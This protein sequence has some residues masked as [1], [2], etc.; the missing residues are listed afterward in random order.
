MLQSLVR[1][2]MG[3]TDA[4][5]CVNVL[6][7]HKLT[8]AHLLRGLGYMS[9]SGPSAERSENL[10]LTL[11]GAS[12][13]D[14]PRPSMPR[15]CAL[16]VIE[17]VK[18]KVLTDKMTI[19]SPS[20]PYTIPTPNPAEPAPFAP[21]DTP[22]CPSNTAMP[23]PV[24]VLVSLDA[25][26]QEPVWRTSCKKC[27][28]PSITGNYGFCGDHRE[29]STMT[30]NQR[31]QQSM[32]Y[33]SAA[34]DGQSI[35]SVANQWYSYPALA[36]A[37]QQAAVQAQHQAQL[38][39]QQ[40]QQL[41]AQQQA[42]AQANAQAQVQAQAQQQA[43]LKTQQQA[44]L[45]AQQQAQA[46]AE[47]LQVAAARVVQEVVQPQAPIQMM[48]V[49]VPTEVQTHAPAVQRYSLLQMQRQPAEVIVQHASATANAI[50][51]QGSAATDGEKTAAASTSSAAQNANALAPGVKAVMHGLVK[52][53]DL[54]GCQCEC[55]NYAADNG[56]WLIKVVGASQEQVF[57]QPKNLRVTVTGGAVAI[58]GAVTT[59]GATHNEQHSQ[60]VHSLAP[61]Q[62]PTPVPTPA[63]FIYLD[64]D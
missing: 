62:V 48:S 61:P 36:E 27:D 52:R 25:G 50:A 55:L 23:P 13:A 37:Q 17:A 38:Q 14:P 39:A 57:L 8:M 63:T 10:I 33:R 53:T 22:A 12:S 9:E 21:S 51:Q 3:L 4:Q 56:R 60:P 20:L 64:L 1:S 59:A 26:S 18:R 29:K 43:Q 42:Q 49:N 11:I 5:V 44:Q 31:V 6:Q 7:A 24:E 28:K 32:G 2:C 15:E 47:A 19:Q 30:H 40:Q 54:N 34:I 41:H 58:T 35:G 46:Q 16:A 45:K